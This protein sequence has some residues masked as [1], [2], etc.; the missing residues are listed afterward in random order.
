MGIPLRA[1]RTLDA[2]DVA[3]AP[4]AAVINESMAK[5]RL[6]GLDPIGQ[7]LHIGP[8][9]GP[10]FTVVGVVSDV[11][12]TSLAVT[13][14]DA[15]YITAEQWGR[16]VDNARWLVVRT[17]Q[18]AAALAPAIRGAIAAVDK[19]QPIIRVAT[20]DERVK[21]SAADRRFAL[22]LFEAFGIAA[23][24]LAAV[25]TYSLLSGSVTERTREM[26][27]RAALGASRSNI[28]TLV[29]R[30]GMVLTGLGIVI[31]LI[32]AAIA[33]RAIVTLLFGVTPLDAVTYAG[34]AVLLAGV[35][36]IAC[37]MPAW[38]AARVRPSV[39]LRF[40]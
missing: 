28:L 23:L 11:T 21:T 19:D 2:H 24:I 14:S 27:V 26:G 37:V 32:G 7:R 10:W 33:S 15:V 38:R 18:D 6:P 5:R 1:G 25:G 3:G 22:L 4:L 36:M 34:V 29:I 35:S 20:M 31:G 16:F 39:A 13:R 30:Q 17:N 40:E 8:N 9:S 12:Q